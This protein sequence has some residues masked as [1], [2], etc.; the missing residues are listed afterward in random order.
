MSSA[1]IAAYF[2]GSRVVIAGQRVSA[3]ADLAVVDVRPDH[4]PI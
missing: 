4:L 2:P 1:S 3:E